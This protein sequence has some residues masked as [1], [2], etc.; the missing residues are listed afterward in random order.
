MVVL[1]RGWGRVS[2]Y[3]CSLRYRAGACDYTIAC[4]TVAAYRRSSRARTMGKTNDGEPRRAPASD[5]GRQI[6][7]AI[8]EATRRILLNDGL[9][10]LTT[11]KLAET[12]G[13]SIGSFYR[14][15][16]DKMVPVAEL[17]RGLER[18]SLALVRERI[19]RLGAP[20]AVALVDLMIDVLLDTE[21]GDLRLRKAI[22][23]V[24]TSWFKG[25]SQETDMTVHQLV[26]D[27][28]ERCRDQLRPGCSPDVAAFVLVR[29]GEAVVE[30][31][32]RDTPPFLTPDQA[33]EEVRTLSLRY[34]LPADSF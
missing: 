30:G 9:D 19:N 13:V 28:L 26:S 31:L 1:L 32:I 17:A 27:E 14:Y 25:L 5:A 33:R 7:D 23:T 22:Q 18:R 21:L 2:G 12:A 6:V 34:L 3:D 15:Y 20:S 10:G 8:L 16:P 11:N 4:L 29:A 24:P